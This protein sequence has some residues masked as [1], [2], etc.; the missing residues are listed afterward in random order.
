[1]IDLEP[2]LILSKEQ[3]NLLNMSLIRSS[4]KESIITEMIFQILSKLWTVVS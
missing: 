1:M 2:K 3:F 4:F